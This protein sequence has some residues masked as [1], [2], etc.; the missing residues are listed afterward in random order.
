MI[1]FPNCKINLGL[2]IL[3]K[4]ND[5]F[6][7]LETIFYPLPL[8]EALEIILEEDKIEV[9]NFTNSGLTLNL[10]PS[11][12]ICVK[13]Y[14][15]LKKDFKELPSIK[16]HLHKTIPAGAGLGGGSADGAF[17]LLLLDKKFNLQIPDIA[18]EKYASRLGSDCTFF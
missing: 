11:D 1:V 17:T 7:D 5:D 10:L 6:H 18:L 12:N 16:I 8:K 13:A 4:R 3:N 2:H 9:V 14:Q 15:L